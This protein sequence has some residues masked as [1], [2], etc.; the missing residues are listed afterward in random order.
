MD[1]EHL[2]ECLKIGCDERTIKAHKKLVRRG[3]ARPP[4]SA[5]LIELATDVF[6]PKTAE[7]KDYRDRLR[8]NI[9]YRMRDIGLWHVGDV[10]MKQGKNGTPYHPGYVITAGPI[11]MA[12]HKHILGP[13]TAWYQQFM[14]DLLRKG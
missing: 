13:Y 6:N 2:E 8:D 7:F 3:L 12:F 9:L 5:G 10:Q 1:P 14:S 11:L 4:G